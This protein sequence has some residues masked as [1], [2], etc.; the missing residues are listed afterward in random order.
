MVLSRLF[1]QAVVT[2]VACAGLGGSSVPVQRE[3]TNADLLREAQGNYQ[4][5]MAGAETG[6][7]VTLRK[8][9]ADLNAYAARNGL[10]QYPSIAVLDPVKADVGLALGLSPVMV[11]Q[12]VMLQ[13]DIFPHR[14]LREI[15]G[16]FLV[17]REL[18]TVVGD[19]FTQDPHALYVLDPN[20][21][22]PCIIIPAPDNTVPVFF[23]IEG[24]STAEA[25]AFQSLHEGWHCLDDRYHNRT[26]PAEVYASFD[27]EKLETLIGNA[28]GLE[29]YSNA[30]KAEVFADIAALGE[31][32]RKGRD[33]S[34]ADKIES[35][36][37][38]NYDRLQHA[39]GPVLKALKKEIE[40]MGLEKFRAQSEAE[41]RAMYYRVTEAHALNPRR[42]EAK[43]IYDRAGPNERVAFEW[44]AT[45]GRETA[46]M[47]AFKDAVPKAPDVS[48][49]PDALKESAVGAAFSAMTGGLGIDLTKMQWNTNLNEWFLEWDVMQDL[50]K[51]AFEADGKVTPE[52]VIRAYVRLQSEL[53]RDEPADP[54][55]KFYY[56]MSAAR[57]K[58]FFV[59]DL[60]EFDFVGTTA[61]A[62]ALPRPVVPALTPGQGRAGLPW[63]AL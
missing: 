43:L 36:R 27:P 39:T 16:Q 10:R 42:L 49:V 59:K 7:S 13:K 53:A 63:R 34:D 31:W 35:W 32:V 29:A 15:V 60:S 55:G 51:R 8:L 18:Q 19:S 20:L 56:T 24:L 37:T 11:A 5:L 22:M 62:A 33:L 44:L 21:K 47:M 25:A 14:G 45:W 58:Y 26:F 54:E 9:E 57:L 38:K 46:A 61:F 41:A 52:T 1:Q 4:A 50:A 17:S 40:G 3:A 30:H 2:A 28:E 12:T 6:Y 23:E 48:D